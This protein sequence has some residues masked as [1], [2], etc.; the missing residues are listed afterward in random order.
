[1]RPGN[2]T[3]YFESDSQDYYIP[4]YAAI[5]QAIAW[6][7]AE[8]RSTDSSGTSQS[9]T[10]LK[11]AGRRGHTYQIRF[12]LAQGQESDSLYD[13]LARYESVIG[14]TGRLFYCGMPMGRVIITDGSFTIATDSVNGIPALSIALNARETTV[15]TPQTNPTNTVRFI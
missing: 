2:I 6:E 1:M 5:T 9:I 8:K 4:S 14:K 3:T 15:Y 10:F 13:I 7:T 12:N 11:K